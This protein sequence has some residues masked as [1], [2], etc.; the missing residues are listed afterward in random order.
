[1]DVDDRCADAREE[2]GREDLHV[3]REDAEV[4]TIR[5]QLEHPLFGLGL[6]LAAD[7]DVVVGHVERLHV[8]PQIRVVGDDADDRGLE[9]T[10]P[11]A[12]EQ[13]EEAMVVPRGEEHHALALAGR[14]E[15]PGHPEPRSHFLGKPPLQL[16]PTLLQPLEP[17]L[18]PQ[19][20]GASLGVGGELVGAEDVRA[21]VE[22]ERRDGRDD[23]VPVGTRDDQT[24]DVGAVHPASL[25]GGAGSGV[26]RT[27]TPAPGRLSQRLRALPV[28][29]TSTSSDPPSSTT[30]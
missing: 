2:V 8:A 5:H 17:E 26:T 6:R 7:R 30:P 11:P 29:A 16:D 22:Q 15:P 3:P 18:H 12:P 10:A 20:E 25:S 1:V 28:A 4:D 27:G 19:E 9:L 13:V 23:P 24:P 21:R 14:H